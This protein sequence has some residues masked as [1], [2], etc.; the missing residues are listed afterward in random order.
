MPKPI[1]IL[2]VDDSATMRAMIKRAVHSSGVDVASL[3]E[4]ANGRDAL[5]VLETQ[6]ID[7]V[8]T[9]LNMPIMSGTELLSEMAAR[10]WSHILRVIVSTDGSAA[11]QDA[12]RDLGVTLYVEKPFTPE[13]IRDV[14][15][16][17]SADAPT[18]A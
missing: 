3:F 2:L 4:A 5:A 18:C 10:N 17:L 13:V 1:N 15:C 8:F 7:A 11:R 16:K 6:S 9:D 14:L 12:V